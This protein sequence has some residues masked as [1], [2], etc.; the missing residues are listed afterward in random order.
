MIQGTESDPGSAARGT[1][2]LGTHLGPRMVP[3]DDLLPHP[4]NSNVMSPDLQ[5]KQQAQ[6]K[7]TGR[8]QFQV[9]GWDDN[10][11]LLRGLSAHP[12]EARHDVAEA[13]VVESIERVQGYV[14]RSE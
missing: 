4:L 3:L 14:Q 2:A 11:P 5:T 10:S 8:H 1:G 13:C 6:S 9:V 7:R 12:F